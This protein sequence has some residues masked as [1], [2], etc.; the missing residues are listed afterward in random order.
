[1]L[2][3][4]TEA[5]EVSKRLTIG[6]TGAIKHGKSTIA[7]QLHNFESNSVLLETG[8]LIVEVADAMHKV[9]PQPIDPQNIDWVNT[10]LAE[11]P[12]ILRTSAHIDV[13]TEAVQITA[14]KVYE[15]PLEFQKLFTHTAELAQDHSE[16]SKPVTAQTKSSHRPFLQWLGGYTVMNIDTGIWYNELLRRADATTALLRIVSGLRFKSDELVIRQAGGYI[17]KVVRPDAPEVDLS[18]PTE[19]ERESI[20]ADSIIINNGDVIELQASTYEFLNDLRAGSP[21]SVYISRR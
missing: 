9:I 17:V 16:L 5:G 20:T 1:M 2:G 10:W 18:D 6:L 11:L 21:K 13:D 12:S 19:R 4:M 8:T 15:K 3:Y 14:Q 7:E